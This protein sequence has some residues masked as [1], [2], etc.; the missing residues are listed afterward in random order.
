MKLT[1]LRFE[2]LRTQNA[3]RIPGV[4]ANPLPVDAGKFYSTDA[5]GH[6]TQYPGLS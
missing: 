5:T 4:D 3:G 6:I 2:R 1:L